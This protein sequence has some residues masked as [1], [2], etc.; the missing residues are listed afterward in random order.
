MEALFT[1]ALFSVAYLTNHHNHGQRCH[2]ECGIIKQC[3]KRR[4]QKIFVFVPS[5]V[6][7]WGHIVAND[8]K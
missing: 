1:I 5:L 7:F 4:E 2:F 6:T 3:C 8:A